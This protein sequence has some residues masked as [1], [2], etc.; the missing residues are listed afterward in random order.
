MAKE[1]PLNLFGLNLLDGSKPLILEPVSPYSV[2]FGMV[3][4]Y[5]VCPY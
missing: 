5:T 2:T 1:M 3:L 4:G